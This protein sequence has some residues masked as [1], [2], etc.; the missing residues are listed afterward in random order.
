[1]PSTLIVGEVIHTNDL[2]SSCFTKGGVAKR[3]SYSG[4]RGMSGVNGAGTPTSSPIDTIEYINIGVFSNAVDWGE[5]INTTYGY[6]CASNG[7]RALSMGGAIAA[8]PEMHDNAWYKNFASSGN[9]IDWGGEITQAR[10]SAENSVASD[11]NRGVLCGG[12]AP[13][14]NTM[15]YFV[16]GTPGSAAIDFGDMTFTAYHCCASQ[17]GSRGMIL[18]GRVTGPT[19][20]VDTLQYFV[21]GSAQNA[22]DFGEAYQGVARA[23][24]AVDDGNRSVNG[25]GRDRAEG[26][27]GMDYIT[28]GTTGNSIDFGELTETG[29]SYHSATSNGH[30]GL[31]MNGKADTPNTTT[32]NAITIGTSCTAVDFGEVASTHSGDGG[33]SGL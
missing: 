30:R 12:G 25:G 33:S 6:G 1:M 14:V 19:A 13:S 11:G 26:L 29:F 28:M 4:Y 24:A 31:F 15:D 32:I 21:I 8:A 9:S 7:V 20:N 2:S 23:L 3:G 22:T 18:F 10:N 16:L 5:A 27:D 17:D